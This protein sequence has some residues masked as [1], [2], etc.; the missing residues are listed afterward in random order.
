MDW[1]TRIYWDLRWILVDFIRNIKSDKNTYD[2]YIG[3]ILFL[4]VLVWTIL[5]G[6]IE[7]QIYD[8]IAFENRKQLYS[9]LK[10]DLSDDLLF[11]KINEL[12]LVRDVIIHNHI[13]GFSILDSERIYTEKIQWKE[14]LIKNHAKNLITTDILHLNIIPDKLNKDDIVLIIKTFKEII[15]WFDNTFSSKFWSLFSN[16]LTTS[17][18]L[19]EQ[20][21][22]NLNEEIDLFIKPK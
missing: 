12:I 8:G 15:I 22:T 16:Y 14:A 13:Y 21:I 5:D 20:E 4:P 18:Y 10:I 11:N 3:Y 9:R 1:K 17:I 6:I 19:S 2:S 7:R